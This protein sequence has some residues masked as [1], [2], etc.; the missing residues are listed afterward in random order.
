EGMA[1]G[2]PIVAT[3]VG[4]IPEMLVG[5]ESGVLVPPGDPEALAVGIVGLLRDPAHREALGAAAFSRLRTHFTLEGFAR[6][7]FETFDQAVA[8]RAR[9]WRSSPWY[10]RRTPARTRCPPASTAS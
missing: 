4:G 10:R 7:M 2:R 6:A 9:G 5:G 1:L 3:A 8:A